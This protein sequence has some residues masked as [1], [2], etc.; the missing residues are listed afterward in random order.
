[1]LRF[2]KKKLVFSAQSSSTVTVTKGKNAVLEWNIAPYTT[3]KEFSIWVSEK[4][5]ATIFSRSGRF[6]LSD[7]ATKKYG[8][9]NKVEINGDRMRLTI[10]D[11]T[12][13]DEATFLAEAEIGL[14]NRQEIGRI[15]LDVS[16]ALCFFN[17]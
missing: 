12:H 7:N 8:K 2:S 17:H 4:R 16:G 11:V 5:M 3:A 13:S 14:N 9:R 10:T 1:M 15:T 6:F